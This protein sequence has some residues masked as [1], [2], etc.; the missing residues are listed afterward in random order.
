MMWLSV[1]RMIGP[2]VGRIWNPMPCSKADSHSS[3]ESRVFVIPMNAMLWCTIVHVLG[4]LGPSHSSSHCTS[5]HFSAAGPSRR[6]L[7]LPHWSLLD[8]PDAPRPTAK[9][10]AVKDG[11]KNIRG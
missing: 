2:H 9:P 1:S 4:S 11:L 10:L 5:S 3:P 7:R 8:P 6:A